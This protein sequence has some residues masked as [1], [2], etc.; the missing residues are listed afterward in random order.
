MSEKDELLTLEEVRAE[1]RGE[2]SIQTLRRRIKNGELR[3]VKPGRSFLVRRQWMNEFIDKGSASWQG[4]D[5]TRTNSGTSGSG[6]GPTARAGTSCGQ[7]ANRAELSDF[8][9]AQTILTRPN[10]N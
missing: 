10:G 5:S 7:T 9:R 6:K 1:L 2:V 8:Q 3:A 4:E